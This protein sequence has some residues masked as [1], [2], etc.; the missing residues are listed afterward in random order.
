MAITFAVDDVSPAPDPAVTRSLREQLGEMMASGC[1][2]EMRV[3]DIEGGHPLLSA[4]HRAFAEHR[5][6]VLSPDAVWLTIAQGLTHHVRLNAEQLRG[7]LTTHAGRKILQVVRKGPPPEDQ[8]GLADMLDAFRAALAEDV[9]AGRT[10]LLLCDFTTSTDVERVA[11][12]ILLL[13]A[14]SPYFDYQLMCVCGIPELTLTGTPSD[15]KSIRA[16]LEVVAEL[17]LEWWVTSLRPVLDRFVEASEGA[18]DRAFFREI[19]KP[20]KAYGWDRITGWI[21]R[22]FPY[23][24]DRGRYTERNPMLALPLDWTP[25]RQD[26]SDWYQG[27]GLISSDVPPGPGSCLIGVKDEISGARFDFVL[28]GGLLAVEQDELGR[29]CPR[30]GWLARRSSVS[31][32]SVVERLWERSWAQPATVTEPLGFAEL[33]AFYDAVGEATLF[34]PPGSWWIRPLRQHALVEVASETGTARL[35]A[36]SST[37]PTTPVWLTGPVNTGCTSS[38]CGAGCC[39]PYRNGKATSPG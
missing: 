25:Q 14:F 16:R 35:S 29:L 37:C 21:T 38:G 28:N 5:P 9:G 7:R 8:A 33:T 2:L 19:Y 23:L 18:P 27:P 1:D 11:S 3:V 20:R 4:V 26:D 17:D 36:D 12:E 31:I 22:F 10:R 24:G 39:V 32:Q 13:D 15:W 30:A 34:D 6:L